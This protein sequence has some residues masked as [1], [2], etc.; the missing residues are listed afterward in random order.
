[1]TI[2]FVRNR[3]VF[4]ETASLIYFVF[5]FKMI[6]VVDLTFQRMRCINYLTLC[7]VKFVMLNAKLHNFRSVLYVLLT[8]VPIH[9]YNKNQLDALFILSLFRQSTSTCFGHM[10]SPSSAGMLYIYIYI[11]RVSQEERT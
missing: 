1:M 7:P 3:N 2:P 11:H 8:C 4:F 6:A 9:L 5:N 10:C